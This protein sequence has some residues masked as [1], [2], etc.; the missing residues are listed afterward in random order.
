M[1]SLRASPS[2]VSHYG[3]VYWAHSDPERE[4]HE[5][6]HRWQ[7]LAEHL[8]SVARIARGLAEAA[9][10]QDC[11]LGE[12][13]F[14]CGM[15]H[16]FGKYQAC[17][18][19]MLEGAFTRCPHSIYGAIALRQFQGGRTRQNRTRLLPAVCAVAA[20]HGG[21]K[22]WS[23]HT[24][25]TRPELPGHAERE[26]AEGLLGE[27]L[28]DTPGIAEVL[29]APDPENPDRGTRDLRTRML[30]SCLVDADRLNTTGRSPVQEELQPAARLGQL[31]G[32]LAR[33]EA[34]ASEK[35]GSAELL[36]LRS[37]VQQR[38]AEAA[39]A[40]RGLFSLCAPT[41]CGKTLATMRFALEHAGVHGQRRLIVVIP[42]LSIIEQN[43]KIYGEVFG[44]DAIFEHHSGAVYA[45]RQEGKEFRVQPE[46]ESVGAE[47]WRRVETENWDAPVIVT[48]S[49][50]FFESLFSNHP[51]DL[52]RIHNIA[53]SVIVLDE[54]QTL[55]RRLLAPLLGMLR[56]LTE[57]WGCS[58]VLSTATQP[59]FE[60][61]SQRPSS[62]AWPAGTVMPILKPERAV[63][64]AD[65]LQ[66]VVI[67]WEIEQPVTWDAL[68]GRIAQH[69]Q[70]LCVV[71]LRD[72]AAALFDALHLALAE[73]AERV[74]HLS[75]RMCAEHRLDVLRRIRERL[76]AGLPCRAISTQLVEAGVDL[77]VPIAFRALGPLDSIIQVAGRVDREGKLTAAAGGPA[78]KLVVFV[79]ED[80]RYPGG[81]K[82]DYRQATLTTL[83][84]LDEFPD[85]QPHHLAAIASYFQRY[86]WEIAGAGGRGEDL[87][88]MRAGDAPRFRT[89]SDA[90]EM[91]E[92]RTISVFVP[93][94]DG[95]LLLDELRRKGVLDRELLRKLQRYTVA[96]QPYEF[97]AGKRQGLYEIFPESD[98]W[99]CSPAQYSEV[100]GLLPNIPDAGYV[101]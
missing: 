44:V 14:R 63:S 20:H 13:A 24:Q 10:G 17:F 31:I 64:M 86:Y 45:L 101:V 49:V 98:L 71:N 89:L 8:D 9:A 18:Q 37:E 96:L 36:A 59:A 92:S 54:V 51:S 97:D 68:A 81:R 53:Q 79:P 3:R 27:A 32:F 75:T 22:D 33:I 82:G 65:A 2:D 94:G 88:E 78:G 19:R 93:Y 7:P 1:E 62:F 29:A 16:D 90:F 35:G 61:A 56:E 15:L 47:V 43:A 58:I 67:H 26:I 28:R 42:Y 100:K 76:A 5:A 52:R 60:A 91:I 50:R 34:R 83:G 69:A 41:G 77:D 30:L 74:F 84:V 72:H 40:R 23:A 66:R 85:I 95:A 48:T 87:A 38:C 4:P 46:P 57:D 80:D 99:T 25:E 39:G 11:S 6:G 12:L 55:P 73:D 21:L 70:V